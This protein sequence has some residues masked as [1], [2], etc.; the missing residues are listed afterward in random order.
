MWGERRG[1]NPS[2]HYRGPNRDPHAHACARATC[3][4][5]AFM[6]FV[7]W[8]FACAGMLAVLIGA[9]YLIS[10][11]QS[12]F[13]IGGTVGFFLGVITLAAWITSRS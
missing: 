8:W 11:V 13:P 2:A 12:M 1:E 5:L 9:M 7:A 4:K 10:A 6:K 3:A